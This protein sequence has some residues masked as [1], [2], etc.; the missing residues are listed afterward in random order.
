M[1][2]ALEEREFDVAIIDGYDP[3]D[4]DLKTLEQVIEDRKPANE[5]LL[6]KSGLFEEKDLS[7]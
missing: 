4:L 5:F 6:K 1:D 2:A 7:W 3:D